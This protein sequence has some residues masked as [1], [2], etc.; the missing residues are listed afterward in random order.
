MVLI[1][2]DV[3]G[4]DDVQTLLLVHSKS[5]RCRLCTVLLVLQL[6]CVGFLQSIT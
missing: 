6:F 1:N 2:P 5:C 3:E 4:T